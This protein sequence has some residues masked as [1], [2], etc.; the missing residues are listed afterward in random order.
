MKSGQFP[1]ARA[2]LKVSVKAMAEFRSDFNITGRTMGGDDRRDDAE[3]VETER[4]NR[5]P[6]FFSNSR[7]TTK[8]KETRFSVD[9]DDERR[10]EGE[11][12]FA[13]FLKKL[14]FSFSV[15]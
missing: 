9:A 4:R 5:L 2:H 14:V 12:I 6:I 7:A 1:L 11:G 13:E 10:E 15:I 8:E 3:H